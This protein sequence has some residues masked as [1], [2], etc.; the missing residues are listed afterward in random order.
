[1]TVHTRSALVLACVT[2][3]L[4]API[5]S[6]QG[7]LDNTRIVFPADWFGHQDLYSVRPDGSDLRQLTHGSEWE[8]HPSWSPDGRFIAYAA[9]PTEYGGEY[10]IFVMNA[11]GTNPVRIT[12]E[13]VSAATPSW[14]P[15]SSRIAF[16]SSN[17][18]GSG[19]FVARR[20]GTDRQR[21]TASGGR[22]SWSPDG[23]SIAYHRFRPAG[24]KDTFYDVFVV[25]TD[26]T[27]DRHTLTIGQSSFSP[28]WSPLGDRVALSSGRAIWTVAPDGSDA[29]EIGP[30]DIEGSH[31]VWSPDGTALLFQSNRSLYT[32]AADGTDVRLLADN[33]PPRTPAGASW[34][35]PLNHP[36]LGEPRIRVVS[37]TPRQSFPTHTTEIRLSVA[38]ENYI[39]PWAWRIDSPFPLGE[40]SPDTHISA[41]DDAVVGGLGAGGTYTAYVAC[42]DA[43]GVALESPRPTS[44]TFTTAEPTGTYDRSLFAVVTSPA[45]TRALRII[46][47]DGKEL[48]STWSGSDLPPSW[49]PDGKTVLFVAPHNLWE[50]PAEGGRATRRTR[51]GLFGEADW[52]PD[53]S[54]IVAAVQLPPLGWEIHVMDADGS[55][56]EQLTFASKG[57]GRSSSRNPVWSPDGSR[58]AYDFNGRIRVMR[59]DGSNVVELGIGDYPCWSPDGRQLAFSGDGVVQTMNADGTGVRTLA[60]KQ[61]S[62][63]RPSWSPDGERIAFTRHYGRGVVSGLYTVARDGTDEQLIHA[64]A[65]NLLHPRWS[66]WRSPSPARQHSLE[67]PP[68]LSDLALPVDVT[69]VSFAGQSM[70]VGR[71]GVRFATRHLISLGASLCVRFRDGRPEI[72]VGRDGRLVAGQDF[73]AP[74]GG[75]LVVNMPLGRAITVEGIP[76]AAPTAGLPGDAW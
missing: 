18:N 69:E 61:V 46:T 50:A 73:D 56:L 13:D 42:V 10:G 29:Q 31:P 49:S 28:A 41:A 17:G 63:S 71:E 12:G 47:G 76:R 23:S 72:A 62:R 4:A 58:I 25:Q 40:P 32:M 64:S 20:D 15:D 65:W 53:G 34:S 43:R 45:G 2:L 14:S 35:P 52:S 27:G 5:A 6:G 48:G 57:A 54:R 26:G 1:M 60:P 7:D 39:G 3:A 11:D 30:A 75:T 19:I 9:R 8:N 67:L 44:V 66:L 74:A 16:V 24:L 22:P 55:N 21:V 68:G 59:P 36:G 37:P 70:L 51:E 33:L 38:L